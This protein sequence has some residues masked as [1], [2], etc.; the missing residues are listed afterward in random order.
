[1]NETEIEEGD[2]LLTVFV[3]DKPIM[4]N[5]VT[6]DDLK[7]HHSPQKYSWNDHINKDAKYVVKGCDTV[8]VIQTPKNIGG[9]NN[10]FIF[11]T[12]GSN[13]SGPVSFKVMKRDDGNWTELV[14]EVKDWL[15]KY[16]PP[17]CLISVSLFED[18]HEN[19]GKGINACITHTAG[20]NPDDITEKEIKMSGPM[21]EL[22]VI[23]GSG[24]W[25]DMFE[26]AKAKINAKGGQ[27]GHIV[28]STNDSSNDGGVIIVLSWSS[29]LEGNLREVTRPASCMDNCTIF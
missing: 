25:E 19:T 20:E 27:E 4:E 7:M 28:A 2:N 24:E 15:N 10:Q 6:F 29:L 1:M 18:A 22:H 14:G 8:S 11:F 26:E 12:K 13:A 17:H 9:V 21:Y 3:R 5:E 16:V 23:A